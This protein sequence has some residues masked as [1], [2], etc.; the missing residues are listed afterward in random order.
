MLHIGIL[1]HHPSWEKY[2]SNLK[3]FVLDE[4]HT[5]TGIFGSH[6]TNVIRRMKRIT[7]F[8]GASPQFILTSA[9]IGNPKILAEKL[10]EEKFELIAQDFSKQNEIYFL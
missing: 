4:I 2:F 1:P 3:F 9:T 10:I 6:L 8:Y 7:K 5:Y